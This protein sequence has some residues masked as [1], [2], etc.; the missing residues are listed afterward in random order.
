MKLAIVGDVHLTE[1]VPKARKDSDYLETLLKKLDFVYQNCDVVVFLGDVFDK[2]NMTTQGLNRV[3]LFFLSKLILKKKSYVV[4]GNHDIPNLNP[5]SVHKSNLGTLGIIKLINIV[6]DPIRIGSISISSI[7]MAKKVV[8]P[9]AP[10]HPGVRLLIGHSFFENSLD[11][12]YSLTEDMVESSGYDY[13]FLGHDHEPH[14]PIK[15]GSTEVHRIGAVCRNTSHSYQ[16]TRIPKAFLFDIDN[17]L[18]SPL[19]LV[20]LPALPGKE[21][22]RDE[23]IKKPEVNEFSFLLSADTLMEQFSQFKDGEEGVTFLS[24]FREIET[25]VEIIEYIR[26]IYTSLGMVLK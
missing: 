16:I 11:P 13:I 24:V 4:M 26:S 15:I 19:G 25:N 12:D 3:I 5:D 2:P 6:N 7:P 20:D 10:D 22:F 1:T 21:V 9:M 8:C 23:A 14:E 17:D 18:V